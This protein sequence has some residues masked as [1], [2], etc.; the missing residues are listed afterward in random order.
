M[1]LKIG[2]SF[3]LI[4][5]IFSLYSMKRPI[6]RQE[7][8]LLKAVKEGELNQVELLLSHECDLTV[9]DKTHATPLIIAA[10]NGFVE[11]LILLLNKGA[12]ILQ[13]IKMVVQY[14]YG[15]QLMNT[16]LP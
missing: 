5:H 12:D 13:K 10:K 14:Y 8:E 2:I 3:F 9:C 7:E 11:I 15:L 4:A 16:T 6:D 1:K